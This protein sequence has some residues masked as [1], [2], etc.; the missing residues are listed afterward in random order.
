MNLVQ[1]LIPLYDE[2]GRRFAASLF[3]LTCAELTEKFGGLTV[4]SRAPAKGFWKKRTKIDR[5]DIVVFEV[6]CQ[7][8][9]AKWWKRYRRELEKRFQQEELVIRA[10][11]NTLL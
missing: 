8:L 10:T 11:Y 2:R 3:D 5:D 7:R 1:I 6:M 4:Y 9:N